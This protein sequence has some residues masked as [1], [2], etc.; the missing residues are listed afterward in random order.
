[1]LYSREWLVGWV[2]R[3]GFSSH[4]EGRE[5]RLLVFHGRLLFASHIGA[6]VS[7]AAEGMEYQIF[8]ETGQLT[9]SH[10][11][12]GFFGRGWKIFP[13]GPTGS[14]THH[15]RDYQQGGT[16]L[17]VELKGPPNPQPILFLFLFYFILFYFIL[18]FS[19][20]FCNWSISLRCGISRSPPT[21]CT[22]SFKL[23]EVK[24]I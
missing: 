9:P 3:A 21:N 11:G 2:L 10:S 6:Y 20:I 22:D 23:S 15:L 8:C 16:V 14:R 7:P 17:P 19:F 12:A 1:M 13:D 5:F 24:K 18:F 4:L